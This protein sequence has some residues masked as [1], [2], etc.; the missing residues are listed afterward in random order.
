MQT[1]GASVSATVC[2]SV[3]A[4]QMIIAICRPRLRLRSLMD[5]ATGARMHASSDCV[6]G[7]DRP[8]PRGQVLTWRVPYWRRGVLSSRRFLLACLFAGFI[9]RG[10][11]FASA[12]ADD[13]G[14]IPL[15]HALLAH[16]RT[17]PLASA[18]PR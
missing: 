13:L 8:G 5:P 2:A 3:P 14:V 6:R 17:R 15:W 9:L 18:L 12:A 11:S 16:E 1:S 10:V 4:A 7:L